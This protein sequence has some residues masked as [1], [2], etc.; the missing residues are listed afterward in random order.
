METIQA[1]SKVL[2][3]CSHDSLMA[4]S[5][6]RDGVTVSRAK[7]PTLG[8]QE[9]LTMKVESTRAIHT[10]G[11]ANEQKKLDFP[12]MQLETAWD[13][14]LEPLEPASNPEPLFCYL[15]RNKATTVYRVYIANGR[16]I[17]T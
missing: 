3:K 1:L 13:S 6:A 8:G 17:N 2:H 10:T 12:Q 5:S 15:R 16:R 7:M 11:G 9:S 4:C 14:L